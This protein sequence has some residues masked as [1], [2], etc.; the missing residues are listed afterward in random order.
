MEDAIIINKSSIERGFG[1]SFFLRSYSVEEKRYFGIER[2][3]I[4][5]PDKSV[6]GYRTEEA[7][8]I[9]GEDG[10]INR[11]TRVK[12][13]DVLVGRVS[14][15]RFFG[16]SESLMVGIENRR[17]TSET[18]RYGEEGIVDNVLVTETISGD[19]IIKI[20]VRSERNPEIGDKFETDNYL[21]YFIS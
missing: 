19:K 16:Q 9:L 17:E 18:V 2:D 6:Q 11:E 1:R 14:P 3:E 4:K 7:Y 12:A 15:L 20:V 10:V 21:Y 5:I 8:S 13:G